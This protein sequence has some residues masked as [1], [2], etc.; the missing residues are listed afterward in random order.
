MRRYIVGGFLLLLVLVYA[1]LPAPP[2]PP[3]DADAT[4]RIVREHFKRNL[5]D[6]A[7]AV[8]HF[9]EIA[10]YRFGGVIACGTVNYVNSAKVY[11]GERQFYAIVQDGAYH[12]G[13]I[14]GDSF[15]DPTGD[16]AFTAKV[17]CK[18]VI[19]K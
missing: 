3:I 19:T 14:V 9:T 7:L 6:P 8:W 5:V 2:L 16:Y 13:G 10:H 11:V 12:D 4:Q 1:F 18:Q 17:A 15:E